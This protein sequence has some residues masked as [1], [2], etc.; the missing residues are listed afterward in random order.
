[1]ACFISSDKLLKASS[2]FL[3]NKSKLPVSRSLFFEKT[4]VL[5]EMYFKK[6]SRLSFSVLFSMFGMIAIFF[7]FSLDNCVATSKVRILSISSPKNSIRYGSSFEKE[8]TS[9]IP[10]L[11]EKSP[12]SVTKSTRLNLYSNKI[13]F[14]KSKDKF[15]PTVTFRVFFS[16]SFLVTTF[17][18][19]AVG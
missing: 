14:T 5:S 9:I 3:K 2:A 15:S 16:N 4:M 13:S 8:N 19:N 11:T 12:G 7:S 6:L 10:P 17:S 1:M 18:N